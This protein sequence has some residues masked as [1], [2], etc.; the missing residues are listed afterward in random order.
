MF[1]DNRIT[2]YLLHIFVQCPY[3]NCNAIVELYSQRKSSL[4]SNLKAN[5][6]VI[7][8][9]TLYF[10]DSVSL[11]LIKLVLFYFELN[12]RLVQSCNIQHGSRLV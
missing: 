3:E 9:G 4:T 10:A 12:L 2:H 5:K 8:F 6:N 7:N 11:I 1:F